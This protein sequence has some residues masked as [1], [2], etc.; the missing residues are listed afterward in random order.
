VA[1]RGQ[2]WNLGCTQ[3]E[4]SGNWYT[5]TIDKRLVS[6]KRTADVAS[7]YIL[8]APAENIMRIRYWKLGF[9]GRIEPEIN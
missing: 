7:L 9:Q 8:K 6:C 5:E 1:H 2:N 4:D 3:Y